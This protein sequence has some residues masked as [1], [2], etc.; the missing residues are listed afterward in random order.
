MKNITVVVRLPKVPIK[1]NKSVNLIIHFLN[2]TFRF[3]G[4][5]L[6]EFIA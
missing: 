4:D 1:Y 2:L 5:K 3:V 6:N